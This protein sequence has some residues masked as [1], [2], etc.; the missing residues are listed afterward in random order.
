VAIP[1]SHPLMVGAVPSTKGAAGET[2]ARIHV[3]ASKHPAKC[4][5]PTHCNVNWTLTT[6]T[7]AV[8]NREWQADCTVLVGGLQKQQG[9]Q[10]GEGEG[11]RLAVD[12][13]SDLH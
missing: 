2:S 5:H 11:W 13:K 9:R 3:S 4:G 8:L 7:R 1:L 10:D 12:A 6:R